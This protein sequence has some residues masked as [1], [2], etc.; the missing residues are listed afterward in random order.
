MIAVCTMILFPVVR[1]YLI[2][3]EKTF[4]IDL[5][6]NNVLG[7]E[8]WSS[9]LVSLSDLK[10]D[11]VG[12]LVKIGVIARFNQGSYEI[13]ESALILNRLA[14]HVDVEKPYLKICA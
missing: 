1:I 12:Y 10:D 6:L 2:V 3:R 8:N 14:R 11:A 7:F 13:S 9:G 4:V 5:P